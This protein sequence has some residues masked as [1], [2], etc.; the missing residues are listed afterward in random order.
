M[1]EAGTQC[2]LLNMTIKRRPS[3][4]LNLHEVLYLDIPK[5]KPAHIFFT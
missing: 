1:I 2:V 5:I 4:T 3:I